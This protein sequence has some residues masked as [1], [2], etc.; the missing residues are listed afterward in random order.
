MDKLTSQFQTALSDAQ[1]LAV[2]R[3]HAFIE[4]L[5]VM[6][7]L[8]DQEGSTIS[9]I[10][11]QSKVSLAGL[12]AQIDAALSRLPQV[13]GTP[14]E[15]HISNELNR[16][17]NVMDKLA[18]K[19]K[20]DYISSELFLLAAVEDTGT[21]GE[22]LRKAGAKTAVLGKAIHEARGGNP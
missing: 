19:R 8:L 22:L 6:K 12:R 7:A 11:T 2:G 14:G 16:I 10:L 4:P 9:H 3:D 21:F 17:V 5:H 13:E 20:D 18:Q 15:I 1:S